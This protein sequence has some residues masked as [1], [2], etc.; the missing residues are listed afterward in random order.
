MKRVAIGLGIPLLAAALLW[1]LPGSDMAEARWI[2]L[3]VIALGLGG[4]YLSTRH[5]DDSDPDSE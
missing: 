4:W 2:S 3:V 5:D 1:W